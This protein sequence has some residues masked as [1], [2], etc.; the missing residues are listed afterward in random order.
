[1]KFSML[2]L[3]GVIFLIFLLIFALAMDIATTAFY[4]QGVMDYGVC[5]CV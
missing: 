5:L 1:M 3:L 2:Q 4:I